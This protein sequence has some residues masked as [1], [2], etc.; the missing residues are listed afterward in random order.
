MSYSPAGRPSI[1]YFP[2]LSDNTLV[3]IF[4]FRFC[5]WTNAP[6]N[7]SPSAPVTVP[8]I[9]AASAVH[10]ATSSTPATNHTLLA[11]CVIA[12]PRTPQ[13]HHDHFPLLKRQLR[14]T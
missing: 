14:G 4:V 6:L 5:A 8:P 9:L 7:G 10:V 12:N 2:V 11:P 13:N 1:A 3:V